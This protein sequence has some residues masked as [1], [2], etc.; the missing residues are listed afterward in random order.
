MNGNRPELLA[1]VGNMDSLYAAVQNGCDAVYLGGKAFGARASAANFEREELQK[2]LDYAHLYGVRVY[3]TVNTLYKD[4]ELPAMLEFVGNLYTDGVDGVILQDI[5]AVEAIR[6]AYPDLVLH[7]STQMTIHN[8]QGARY[9]EQLGFT[10]V[11]LARELTLVEIREI[12]MQTNIEV[13]TFVHGALCVCYSGQCL[14]SS[15]IGGRSGNRGRCAQPCR[16]PYQLVDRESGQMLASLPEPRYLLSPKDINSLEILPELIQAGIVSFKIEGR[17]KRPEYAASV[18]RIYR[19][20]IDQALLDPEHYWIEPQAWQEITQI[21][22]R[23]GF[24]TGYYQGKSGST[25][26]SYLRPKN[27]GIKVGEVV[28]YDLKH[29]LCT[30]KLS[31]KLK[32]GDGVEIWSKEENH[33]GATIRKLRLQGDRATF[34]I[35]GQICP[36]DPVYRTSQKDL[37]E[38]LTQSYTSYTRQIELYGQ[39]ALRPGEPMILHLW[40]QTG[41][42]IQVESKEKVEQ[43][44]KHPLSADKV[45]E[46]I[47]KLGNL[48]FKL[49][50]LQMDIQGD[51]FIPISE[52]NGLRRKGIKKLTLERIR[53]FRSKRAKCPVNLSDVIKVS[54]AGLRVVP[55]L[56]V[57]LR[58]QQFDP[59][60]FAVLG[61]ERIYLDLVVV[62]AELVSQLK[63]QNSDLKVFAMLP[64]IARNEEITWIK[65]SLNNLRESKLDGIYVSNLGEAEIMADY[66]KPY[67]VNFSLN[68][69]NKLSINYWAAHGA[70]SVTLSPELNLKEMEELLQWIDIPKEVI[71]YG[72][73]PAMESEYCPVNILKKESTCQ[74]GITYGLLDRKGMIFP[75]LTD[76]RNCRSTILNS[77]PLFLLDQLEDVLKNSFG[78]LRMDL[79]IES[80][81]EGIQLV[82]QYLSR[83]R[84]IEEPLTTEILTIVNRM[85]KR[86]FTRGHFYRGVE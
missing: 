9:L 76:C 15:L 29:H 57:Y 1:P 28:S 16:L 78:I 74:S 37:L 70:R 63:E 53:N 84:G 77:Q 60:K 2:A 59:L 40:D 71:V 68:T 34:S 61:I 4:D 83:M 80:E 66:P 56:A 79:T 44:E 46:Q 26:M 10:R 25:M 55:E 5:G 62:T 52:L 73:L 22:N 11:V 36:G 12:I 6:Q 54:E 23:G 17:M 13:E 58:G 69:M 72:Y 82:K 67:H 51:I 43:A 7:A 3:V 24:S 42:Y 39:I 38:E 65:A 18:T 32:D 14:M 49:I 85:Q 27:W 21:F 50:D 64:R 75:V 33:P 86:G 81:E 20:Y 8:V 48:P 30:A 47:S 31:G 19:Q 45:R 35:K 41:N